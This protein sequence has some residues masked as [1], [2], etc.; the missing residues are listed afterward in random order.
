MKYLLSIAIVILSLPACKKNIQ[1]DLVRS[2]PDVFENGIGP[3]P[4]YQWHQM[5]VP[6]MT[7]WP[8]NDVNGFNLIIPV[9]GDVYDVVAND[10]TVVYKL[11]TITKQWALYNAYTI[12]TLGTQYIF[13]Y[14]SKIYEGLDQQPQQ[15]LNGFHSI[16]PSTHSNQ[17]L[18]PF[19]GTPVYSFLS[20]TIGN[21]G[22]LLGGRDQQ[23]NLVN[24]FWEYNFSTNQWTNKGSSPLGARAGAVA[25]IVDGKAYIGL[26]YAYLN[27]NGLQVKVYKNDWKMYD[28]NA[29]FQV[30]LSDF[31]GVRRAFAEGF[32]LNG[33]PYVGFGQDANG[34]YKDLYK[35]NISSDTWSQ[36]DDWPGYHAN[37]VRCFSI[38][39]TGYVTKGAL[40][41]FW[42]FSNSVFQ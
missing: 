28:P 36:Q 37:R 20:F 31:P 39:S 6:D 4:E 30:I 14:Q 24:Q 16:D 21:K 41:E 15:I 9:N 18:A 29:V 26:G 11:N 7:S 19:P 25:M 3:A 8:N 27:I 23:G 42:R 38:G 17:S 10:G 40:A 2:N 5:A 34:D 13:S 32:V 1:D 33:S 12:F 35:Y 22:Y